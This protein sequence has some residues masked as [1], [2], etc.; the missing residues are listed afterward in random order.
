MMCKCNYRSAG[1]YP[2]GVG[3]TAEMEEITDRWNS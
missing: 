3:D 2:S 1:E